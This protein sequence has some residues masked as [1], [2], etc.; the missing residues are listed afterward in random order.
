MAEEVAAAPV[1]APVAA[2]AAAPAAAP[3]AA[4]A[5]AP[6]AATTA[7]D[8]LTNLFADPVDPAVD[9][10]ADPTKTDPAKPD[11]IDPASYALNLPEGVELTDEAVSGVKAQLAA[12]NVSPDHAQALFDKYTAGIKSAVEAT[13]ASVKSEMSDGWTNT[14]KAWK[15]EIASDPEIG[16]SKQEGVIASIRKGAETLL[17]ANGA[18]EL[19]TALNITG[20]GNNPAIVRAL[21]KAFA[22]HAPGSSVTGAPA[23]GNAP[24]SPGASLYPNQ[25]KSPLGN[26]N[27]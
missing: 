7:A 1:A 10:A 12:A 24:R 17:G 3:V 22:M 23:G 14:Q 11:P 19:Y 15:A 8:P 21:N 25:G 18:K 5:P 27:I 4:P 16:G 20:A 26:A 13:R 2:P 6:A 9:P